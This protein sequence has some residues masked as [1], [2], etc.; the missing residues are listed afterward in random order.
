MEQRRVNFVI[1]I[2]SA[3]GNLPD[4]LSGFFLQKKGVL[5]AIHVYVSLPA[6]AGR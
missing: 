2:S 4:S 6:D 1:L 3:L 5:R